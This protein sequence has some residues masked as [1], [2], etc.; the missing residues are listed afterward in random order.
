MDILISVFVQICLPAFMLIGLGWLLD[1]KFTLHLDSLVKLNLQVFVPAF[2]LVQLVE[3]PLIGSLAARVFLFTV[4]MIFAM[5]AIASLVALALRWESSESRVLQITSMFQNAGN[6]GIPL[7]ALAY[8]GNGPALEVFVIAGVNIS[9]FTLGVF[10]ASGNSTSRWNWR[11]VLPMLRQASVWA[12]LSA[13]LIRQFE[14]PVTEWNILW[15]PLS[16][17][18]DALIAVALLTLGVQLSKTGH[19]AARLPQVSTALVLRLIV[20]PLIAVPIAWLYGF[21]GENAAI[22]ILSTAFPTAVNTALV[23]HEFRTA[24][25]LAASI[26]FYSTLAGAVT[27]TLVVTILKISVGA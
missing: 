25:Q 2:I 17:L 5:L 6:F 1:K 9:T 21:E 7:M 11:R 4:T 27:V 13:V 14:I 16:Y 12:I 19:R 23:A 22:V 20:A 8:P 24:P 18:K 15:V 3:S 26:V 10:I